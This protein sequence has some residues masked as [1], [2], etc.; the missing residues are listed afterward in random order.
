MLSLLTNNTHVKIS[1]S[2]LA[3]GMSINP[4]QCRKLKLSA[5]S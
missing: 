5:K 1:A 2:L 4:K 3:D